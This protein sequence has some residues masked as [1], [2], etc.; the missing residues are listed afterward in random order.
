M[1]ALL[2][3]DK[4]V[5]ILNKRLDNIEITMNVM[6][7]SAKNV[8]RQPNGNDVY[9]KVDKPS[10]IYAKVNKVFKKKSPEPTNDVYS[11]V[12][13]P[14]KEGQTNKREG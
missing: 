13:K 14:K 11:Q 8:Q 5:V 4:I 6:Y 12:Q 9:A 7:E 2:E 10:N 1:R 3:E